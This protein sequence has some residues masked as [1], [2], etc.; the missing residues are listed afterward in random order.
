MPRL[1]PTMARMKVKSWIPACMYR[2]TGRGKACARKR[3]KVAPRGRRKSQ[4]MAMITP[5]LRK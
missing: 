1:N 4:E 3:M 5:I 2:G